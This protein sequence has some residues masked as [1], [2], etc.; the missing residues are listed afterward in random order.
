MGPLFRPLHLYLDE[1]IDS[2]REAADAVAERSVALDAWPDG[3]AAAI[4]AAS[5]L[6]GLDRG[7]ILDVDVIR[8]L[9]RRLAE[10]A[11]RVRGRI[12][13]LAELDSVSEGILVGI[14]R[15]LEEQMWMVRAQSA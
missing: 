3:Q 10:V 1:L 11:E 15:T 9:V 7:P 13:H 2:W 6:A 4:A 8:E 12:D 14:V 5:G